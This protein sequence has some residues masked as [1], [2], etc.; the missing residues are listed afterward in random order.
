[1]AYFLN[2]FSPET[3][4][5][6]LESGAEMTGFRK[7]M[8]TRAHKKISPGDIFIC[9]LRGTSR[10][11]GA[12]RVESGAYVEEEDLQGVFADFP[13]RFV[14][15]TIVA[16]DP[17]SMI[18]AKDDRVQDNWSVAKRYADAPR[19]SAGFLSSSLR[20]IDDEDGDFFLQYLKEQGQTPRSSRLLQETET[21]SAHCWSLTP[22]LFPT[23]IPCVPITAS[24][25]M[26]TA[27]CTN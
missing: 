10:W 7:S 3:W 9:Y 12:L 24:P 17:E 6:F 27:S 18:P 11:C 25:I 22:P 14:V 23:A 4:R 5:A 20:L 16:L 21:S 26:L 8:S 15:S 2:L 1:M 13:V 19:G